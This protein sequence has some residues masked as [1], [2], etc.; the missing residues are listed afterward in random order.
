ME[1]A[2]QLREA[3]A[4]LIRGP[5]P[6]DGGAGPVMPATTRILDIAVEDGMARIDLSREV[7]TDSA[8]GTLGGAVFMDAVILTATQFTPVDRVQVLVE[9]E[10]WCDGHFLWEEPLG[11]TDILPSSSS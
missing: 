7:L 3:M 1:A 5:G 11:R 2:R 10:P 9:G 8:G 4:E 6:E